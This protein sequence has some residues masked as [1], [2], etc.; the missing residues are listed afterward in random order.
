MSYIEYC[1]KKLINNGYRI[2]Q[3]RI[4]ILETLENQKK[5]LNPYEI[6]KI[7]SE[8]NILIDT[9]TIYRILQIFEKHNLVHYLASQQRYIA[10]K[11][12]LCEKQNNC[13]HQF[14]CRQCNTIEE[15]KLE[16]KDFIN[17]IQSQYQNISITHHSLEL[18]GL[19]QKC[20]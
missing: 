1:K 5:T 17:K 13:H 11:D 16:D 15:L 6:K 18:S 8:K 10:C 3:S 7:L 2:T 20:F 4:I 12:W 14:I 19:C 9:S